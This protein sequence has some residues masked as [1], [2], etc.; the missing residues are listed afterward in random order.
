MIKKKTKVGLALG[1]GGARGLAHIGVIRALKENNIPIDIITGSSA[2]S[3]IGGLYASTNSV[4][5]VEE[6]SKK[7]NYLDIFSVFSRKAQSSGIFSGERIETYLND[8]LK[9]EKIEKLKIPFAAIAT[10]ITTGKTITITKGDL[11]KAIRASSSIPALIN[12][13][14]INNHLLVDGGSSCPVPVEAAKK[15]GADFIIAV[16]LDTYEF[17]KP[18]SLIENIS[19]KEMGVA[20]FN[21]LRSSLSKELCKSADIVITPNVSNIPSFNL[22]NFVNGKKV[23]QTGY[24]ATLELI[25]KIKECIKTN[26]FKE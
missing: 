7:V 17:I 23:I 25:E 11:A 22:I 6:I 8:I 19:A 3:L 16:N 20:A 9:E 2:G 5:K 13:V 12:A 10:D 1:S 26:S 18:G 14:E 24:E 15:L 21:I 4:E